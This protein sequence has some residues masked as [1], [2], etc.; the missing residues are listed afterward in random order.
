MQ[1]RVRE[2]SKDGD[3][4]YEMIARWYG[5]WEKECPPKDYLPGLG[6]IVEES[7][8]GFLYSTDSKVCFFDCFISDPNITDVERNSA[9]DVLVHCLM[10]SAKDLD[11]KVVVCN[12]INGNIKSRALKHGFGYAGEHG[13]FYKELR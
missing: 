7:V 4:D 13:V 11:N 8:A 1:M 9:L 5:D 12:S 6:I 2:F 3:G 10:D